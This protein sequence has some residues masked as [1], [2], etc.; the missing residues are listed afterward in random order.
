MPKTETFRVSIH[1]PTWGATYGSSALSSTTGFQSTLPRGERHSFVYLGKL[2]QMFQSTLPRGERPSTSMSVFAYS[3]FQSTLPRGERLT[4]FPAPAGP[5]KFQST[6]P[7]GERR[8][9]RNKTTLHT[10]FNPRSHV[11]S[12]VL[13]HCVPTDEYVSIH[14]PTWGAT[15]DLLFYTRISAVSIHAPTWGATAQQ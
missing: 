14:A 3:L 13:W 9:K 11:G 6:L 5:H 4:F 10:C 8:D 12:D 15:A 7:R 2:G 1:A